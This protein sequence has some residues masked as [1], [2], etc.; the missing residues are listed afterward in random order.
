MRARGAALTPSQPPPRQEDNGACQNPI[1]L[2][3]NFTADYLWGP[4]QFGYTRMTARNA[5]V[6]HLEQVVVRP[7]T[8]IWKSVDIVQPSHG[9][10]A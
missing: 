10:F 1:L 8:Q 3:S 6:L 5:S 7:T 9:P 2:P 4:A